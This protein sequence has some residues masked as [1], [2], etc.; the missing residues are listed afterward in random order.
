MPITKTRPRP[1]PRPSQRR[2][3]GA[4]I[5]AH[6]LAAPCLLTAA[7]L[8]AGCGESHQPQVASLPTQGGPSTHR[9]AVASQSLNEGIPDPGGRPRQ[10]LN[11]TNAQLAALYVPYTACLRAHNY[12]DEI[13]ASSRL[14][15]AAKCEQLAPLPAWQVDPSNP[16]ARAFVGR[17]VTCLQARGYHARAVLITNDPIQAPSW[18]I[19]Y[20]PNN[21][22]YAPSRPA[23]AQDAC[24]QQALR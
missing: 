2:G 23:G 18:F 19:N 10:P 20:S 6:E 14:A 7:L 8:L 21:L 4:R 12:V 22:N 5:A 11:A 1:R 9:S 16:Q 17:T 24:Q 13:S 15:V 3:H